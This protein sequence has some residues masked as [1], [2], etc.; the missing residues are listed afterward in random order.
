MTPEE[1]WLP[2]PGYDG[3]YEASSLGRVRSKY[4]Q[5]RILS[6]KGTT[7]SGYPVVSLN[8]NGRRHVKPAALTANA[9]RI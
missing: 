1:I 4:R 6:T 3:M 8:R 5:C 7:E 9:W 2:I